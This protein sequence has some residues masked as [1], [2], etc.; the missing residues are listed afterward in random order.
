MMTSQVELLKMLCIKT[1]KFR[2]LA[3]TFLLSILALLGLTISL[4]LCHVTFFLFLLVLCIT[5]RLVLT[6]RL[7]DIPYVSQH[8]IIAD[9]VGGACAI[10]VQ[11]L[12]HPTVLPLTLMLAI[13]IR[14]GDGR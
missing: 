12:S 14:L 10:P 8:C 6:S 1:R 5:D 11:P 3:T 13:A 7:I 2:P 4:S 9:K